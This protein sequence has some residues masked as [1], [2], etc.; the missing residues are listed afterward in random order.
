MT[1]Q[2]LLR[3]T[4]GSR[5]AMT[6]ETSVAFARK[7]LV[8]MLRIRIAI[9]IQTAIL[10]VIKAEVMP[11]T[12]IAGRQMHPHAGHS[13]SALRTTDLNMAETAEVSALN[14]AQSAD[15]SAKAPDMASANASY[16]ASAKASHMAATKAS[17]ARP[18]RC[19]H[20]TAG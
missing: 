10:H 6:S 8:E 15:M 12:V 7:S 2:R 19:V 13:S 16:M 18:R 5:S 3:V 11:T 1:L 9:R 4:R 20:Q 17:S 14:P